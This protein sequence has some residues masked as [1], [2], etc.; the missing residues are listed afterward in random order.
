MK[1]LRYLN[2]A[3]INVSKAFPG[4]NKA[5]FYLS[6]KHIRRGA[7]KYYLFSCARVYRKNTH[8]S[9]HIIRSK[10]NRDYGDKDVA[11]KKLITTCP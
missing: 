7:Q 11:R 6:T 9:P 5:I 1:Y 4:K 8:K 3:I 10:E 2:T